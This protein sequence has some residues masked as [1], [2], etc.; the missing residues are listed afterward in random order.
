MKP[1]LSI[2]AVRPVGTAEPN[3]GAERHAGGS[4][5]AGHINHALDIYAHH[6]CALY[7]RTRSRCGQQ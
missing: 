3:A 7:E 2:C 6:V 1:G 5:R 4:S